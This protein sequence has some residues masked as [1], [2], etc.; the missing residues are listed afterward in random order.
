MNTLSMFADCCYSTEHFNS[1]LKL[2]TF[3][4]YFAVQNIFSRCEVGMYKCARDTLF[5]CLI[6][7]SSGITV[8]SPCTSEIYFCYI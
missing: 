5:A 7:M 4:T 8:K 1:N 6:D 3:W 2:V